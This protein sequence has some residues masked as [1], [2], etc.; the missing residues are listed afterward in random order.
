MT[1]TIVCDYD[2]GSMYGCRP[3]C[4]AQAT[5]TVVQARSGGYGPFTYR[6]CRRHVRPMEGRLYPDRYTITEGVR[7]DHA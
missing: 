3:A 5:H 4:S 6:V 2:T 1:T 7:S